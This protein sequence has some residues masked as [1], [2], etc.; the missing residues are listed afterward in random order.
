MNKAKKETNEKKEEREKIQKE[1]VRL[2]NLKGGK[3]GGLSTLK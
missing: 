3:L 2:L 1:G